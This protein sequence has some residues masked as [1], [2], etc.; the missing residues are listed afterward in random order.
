MKI[1][2]LCKFHDADFSKEWAEKFEPVL[3]RRTG[4]LY[5]RLVIIM[6]KAL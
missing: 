1:E 5:L 6:G 4:S 3:L 2:A